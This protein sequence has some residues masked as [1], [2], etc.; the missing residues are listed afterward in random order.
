M[1]RHQSTFCVTMQ[2]E[3]PV[4]RLPPNMVPIHTVPT[5][6]NHLIRLIGVSGC[7]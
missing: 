7:V 6:Y 3:I 1:Q 2:R 5:Y 4:M